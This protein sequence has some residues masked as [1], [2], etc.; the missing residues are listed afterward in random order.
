MNGI[1]FKN[2]CKAYNDNQVVHNLNLAVEQ[3]ERLILLGPSGCGKTTTLRMAA[4]LEA[5]TSG[6]LN[7]GGKAVNDLEP[8]E[9][10]VAMV[11]Q[12]Y[13]L[14]PHMTVWENITF[15]LTIQKVPREE[16]N[17][18]VKTA[19]EILN[20]TGYE[21][22]KPKELSGGQKQRVALGRALVKQAPFFLLD[23]PLS[24]LDAQL[25]QQ[26]RTELVKIHE[27][28]RPTMMYVTHDQ[29]EA[30]T[31]GQRI[32]IMNHGVLQQLDTPDNIYHKPANAFVASFIG[33][34]PMNLIKGTFEDG[35]F[36]IAGTRL[37]IPTEWQPLV[38]QYSQLLLGLRPEH[39]LLTSQSLFA[40]TAEF[41][42]HLGSQ[43]CIHVRLTLKGQ[44][45]LC[46]VPAEQAISQGPVNLSFSW[47]HVSLFD[48][49]S[50]QNIGYPK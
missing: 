50:G 1:L 48:A 15:G 42:E 47:K 23:E 41:I 34:P 5:I 44:K 35:A 22:R 30:M 19:L 9:R 17:A 28:Y 31:V 32:A 8:G 21:Q 14:Y 6:T 49:A 7:M 43:H 10:N 25:R 18:R 46:M 11:F 39:C 13:A 38:A 45:V 24:N 26:A 20:L 2:V 16:I 12:N 29:V 40:G 3:G 4:G 36:W 37:D 27:L 33:I